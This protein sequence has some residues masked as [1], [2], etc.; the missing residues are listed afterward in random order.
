MCACLCPPSIPSSGPEAQ[1]EA[2]CSQTGGQRSTGRHRRPCTCPQA[3]PA[4]CP[5]PQTHHTFKAA[6]PTLLAMGA[7]TK[8]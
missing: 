4:P 7:R 2:A 3:L 8:R 1:E 5:H 6:Q